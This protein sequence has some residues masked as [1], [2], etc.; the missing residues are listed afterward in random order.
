MCNQ[1]RLGSAIFAV[2]LKWEGEREMAESIDDFLERENTRP[3]EKD[4]VRREAKPQWR[5]LRKEIAALHG[6]IVRESSFAWLE[7]LSTLTLQ[8][9]G[10]RLE[11]RTNNLR[12]VFGRMSPNPDGAFVSDMNFS[13]EVWTPALGIRNGQFVWSVD[14]IEGEFSAREFAAQIG[15]RLADYEQELE[16]AANSFF[17]PDDV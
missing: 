7:N 16:A 17:E 5:S 12:I 14:E 6:K 11:E 13:A 15:R 1:P 2:L 4:L 3:R 10:V 8:G 9:V